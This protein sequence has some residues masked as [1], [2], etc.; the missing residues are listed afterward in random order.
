MN[1]LA[2]LF[3]QKKNKTTNTPV[4]EAKT[5]VIQ[6][7]QQSIQEQLQLSSQSSAEQKNIRCH[8]AKLVDQ[9]KLELTT[10]EATLTTRTDILAILSYCE[11][12]DT[13]NS[14]LQSIDSGEYADLCAAQS[15]PQRALLIELINNEGELRKLE[16]QLRGH[17]KTHLRIVRDKIDLI[18]AER[19][20]QEQA[21][22]EKNQFLNEVEAHTQRAFGADFIAQFERL[23]RKQTRLKTTLSEQEQQRVDEQF[24]HCQGICEQAQLEAQQKQ[25][26]TDE[27]K[28]EA[29]DTAANDAQ[30]Q[31]TNNT[32]T[33][34]DAPAP[35]PTAEELALAKEKAEKAKAEKEQQK[36]KRAD[37]DKLL[38]SLRKAASAARNGQLKRAVAMRH[39]AEREIEA[40]KERF[41]DLSAYIQKQ[42]DSSNE[43]VQKLADWHSYASLP[44][45]E[46]LVEKIKKLAESPLN[47]EAQAEKI[48][49]LQDEWKLLS[50][51][52]DGQYQ[53]LWEQFKGAADKAYEVCKEHYD[54]LDQQRENNAKALKELC[55]QLSDYH[56]QYNWD[57]A[58]W[59]D[60][61]SLLN[62]ARRTERELRPLPRK[63]QKSLQEETTSA[64]NAIEAKVQAWWQANK[65]AK[66]QL[67][68]SLKPVVEH[69]EL[70]HAV[71]IAIKLQKQ[72][73]DIGRC[74]RREEQR[75]WKE[76][77]QLCDSVFERRNNA[78]DEQKA[79]EQQA[80]Q[81]AESILEQAQ[82]HLNL[83]AD[84]LNKKHTELEELQ[85]QLHAIEGLDERSSRQLIGKFDKVISQIDNKLSKNKENK[86][87]QRWQRI[88]ELKLAAN[89]AA[90]SQDSSA[91]DA[92]KQQLS[93]EQ[94]LPKSS[95]KSL[96]K[97]LNNS[98][99]NQDS[100]DK[101]LRLLCIQAEV[102]AGIDSPEE[103]KSLRMEFQMQQLQQGSRGALP[104][105]EQL[106]NHWLT[107]PLL[108]QAQ[109]NT[110]Q[111]RFLGAWQNLAT[112]QG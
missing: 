63:L 106:A 45:L 108:D 4:S 89:D 54:K 77:R 85:Q 94:N 49:Q 61:E 67:I 88:F 97:W 65:E 74:E 53:E 104:D 112:P 50:K 10:L 51:G 5:A 29:V 99:L 21:E 6:W 60:V 90:L 64:L 52:S 55:Q 24:K 80:K 16:K 76:F 79:S 58:N 38:I 2:K 103:D 105:A 93:E 35:S 83:E 69:P 34:E 25:G 78:R 100:S 75:L 62:N 86:Q 14:Y 111:E 36:A 44:K 28:K 40:L 9:Q 71:D 19:Q 1:L 17:D 68:N 73:K 31:E 39:Q 110:L 91:L 15:G 42:V 47:A 109:L 82:N 59:T 27:E 98:D 95:Q 26:A 46:A 7:Q 48:K 11:S 57:K 96:Q 8:L 12:P 18:K 66:Q 20:E 101:A 41:G 22:Q 13:T 92:I 56:Q 72:W 3:G 81:Q 23:K 30:T 43:A 33:K 87:Q 102:L 107:T 84:E 37:E 70:Q 32:E